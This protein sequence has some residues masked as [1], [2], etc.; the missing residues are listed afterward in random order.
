MCAKF[1]KEKAIQEYEQYK[2]IICGFEIAEQYYNMNV[3]DNP[4]LCLFVK[5]IELQSVKQVAD[6]FKSYGVLCEGHKMQPSDV[7]NI[8]YCD[9]E[10]IDPNIIYLAR[11]IFERNSKGAS[12][13]YN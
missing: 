2:T 5:Y 3:H 1:T 8:I 4:I 7:S 6:L 12:Y 11:F 9:Y 13:R 10:G